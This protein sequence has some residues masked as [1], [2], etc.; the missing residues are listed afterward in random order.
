MLC[1]CPPPVPQGRV[2]EVDQLYVPQGSVGEGNQLYVSQGRVGE[3]GTVARGNKQE[4]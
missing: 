3:S 1:G 2:G 4:L